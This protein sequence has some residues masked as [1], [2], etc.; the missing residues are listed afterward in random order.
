[1]KPNPQLHP[2]VGRTARIE[3]HPAAPGQCDPHLFPSRL[4]AEPGSRGALP[5]LLGQN[6]ECLSRTSR[7]DDPHCSRLLHTCKRLARR[8]RR[9]RTAS[10]GYLRHWSRAGPGCSECPIPIC[11]RTVSVASHSEPMLQSL[12]PRLSSFLL[13]GSW[14]IARLGK[15]TSSASISTSGAVAWVLGTHDRSRLRAL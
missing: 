2:A 9:R 15:S 5:Y 3:H 11:F 1:M 12:L 6:A 8:V 13:A 7:S 4:L 14:F 10:R